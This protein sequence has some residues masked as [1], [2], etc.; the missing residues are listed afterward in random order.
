MSK[1]LFEHAGVLLQVQYEVVHDEVV[2]ESVHAL[3]ADYRPVGPDLTSLLDDMLICDTP[4]CV[5]AQRILS[6]IAGEIHEKV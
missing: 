2:F 3:D 4:G 6:K 1:Q 5:E